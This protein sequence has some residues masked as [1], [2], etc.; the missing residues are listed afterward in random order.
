[1][2]CQV[3]S[4]ERGVGSIV[5]CLDESDKAFAWE[6]T[7]GSTTCE[8]ALYGCLDEGG[9]CNKLK[10]AVGG[11]LLVSGLLSLAAA[12]VVVIASAG[13]WFM[14]RKFER[15]PVLKECEQEVVSVA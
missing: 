8:A 4:G 6:Y 1:V 12:A 11:Y 10:D 5:K 13:A 15:N 7:S 14:R 9:C 2:L 3:P